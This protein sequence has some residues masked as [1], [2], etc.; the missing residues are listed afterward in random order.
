MAESV[1]DEYMNTDP[2][3]GQIDYGQPPAAMDFDILTIECSPGNII[4]YTR[5]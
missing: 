2:T 4:F 3:V 1:R 5:H